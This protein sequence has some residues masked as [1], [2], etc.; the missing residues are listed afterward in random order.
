M[1][2]FMADNKE[3]TL[4]QIK[5]DTIYRRLFAKI[6]DYILIAIIIKIIT[7]FLPET[8]YNFNF[9]NPDIIDPLIK[10]SNPFLD[11]WTDYSDLIVSF[12]IISYFVI[13]NFFS[14]QTV[15]KM[16]VNVK[17][18]DIDEIKKLNFLQAVLR[19]L[20]DIF[21]ALITFFI[22][23]EYLPI[24][25]ISIWTVANL[26]QVFSNKRHLTIDDLIAKTVVLRVSNSET[27]I[28]IV[29]N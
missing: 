6:L 17:I 15:G 26:I 9:E 1:K 12:I 10:N 19:N 27:E 22:E 16:I 24:I 8:T 4:Q 13:F 28:D 29:E 20:S 2:N 11:I 23:V 5:Y 3:N 18:R 25:L 14:G 21:F 7:L